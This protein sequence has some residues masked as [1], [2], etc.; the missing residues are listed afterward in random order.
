MNKEATVTFRNNITKEYVRIMVTVNPAEGNLF[1][2]IE[3]GPHYTKNRSGLHLELLDMLM[4]RLAEEEDKYINKI[5]N[6]IDNGDFFTRTTD[7]KIR[8]GT[9]IVS[10]IKELKEFPKNTFNNAENRKQL[11]EFIKSLEP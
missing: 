6:D 1:Q 5:I 10:S 9:Q 4:D 2:S 3:I 7:G 11:H 8:Y